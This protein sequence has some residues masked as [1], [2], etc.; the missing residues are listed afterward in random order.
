MSHVIMIALPCWYFELSP[1][2]ELY[3]GKLVH[4]ITLIP[5]EIFGM[6]VMYIRSRLN[7][8]CKNCS[9]PL[10]HFELSPLNQLNRGKFVRSITLIP[11]EMFDDK[12]YTYISGPEAVSRARMVAPPCCP[13][14]LSP[15]N[16]L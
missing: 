9:S 6:H 2:N 11:F 14:E 15:L 8:E 7:V 10:L 3:S 13:F 5:F 12:C 4:L 16:L 1:L